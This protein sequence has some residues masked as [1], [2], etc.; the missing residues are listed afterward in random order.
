MNKKELQSILHADEESL[1]GL[2][3][4]NRK[5]LMQ[6]ISACRQ[7]LANSENDLETERM[8][9]SACGVIALCNT[10]KTADKQRKIHQ[11][12]KSDSLNNVIRAVDAEMDLREK[13]EHVQKQLVSAKVFVKAMANVG[14]DFGYGTYELSDTDICN[15]RGFLEKLEGKG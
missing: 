7:Q 5:E 6:V 2:R 11:D 13:L 3:Y 1:E 14:V 15:A 4:R 9:L 8:R 12:Y 10:K